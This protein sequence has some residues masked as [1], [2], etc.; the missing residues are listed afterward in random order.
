MQKKL[1]LIRFNVIDLIGRIG[2]DLSGELPEQE[3]WFH[4]GPRTQANWDMV[5]EGSTGFSGTFARQVTLICFDPF[6]LSRSLYRFPWSVLKAEQT[7][8]I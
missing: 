8:R 3:I 1:D 5:L 6:S 4:A 7:V 2:M